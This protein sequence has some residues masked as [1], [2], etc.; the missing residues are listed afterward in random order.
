MSHARSTFIADEKASRCW[1]LRGGGDGG[2]VCRTRTGETPLMRAVQKGDSHMA[3][4]Q[5]LLEWGASLAAADSRGR[6]AL[7]LA[8]KAR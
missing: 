3:V 8:T 6:T 2:G 4:V 5:Q 1:W 7:D